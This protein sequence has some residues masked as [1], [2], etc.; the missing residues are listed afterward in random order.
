MTPAGRATTGGAMG[1]TLAL[2]ALCIPAWTLR[3]LLVAWTGLVRTRSTAW[4][5]ARANAVHRSSLSLTT[6][7]PFAIAVGMT[8]AVYATVGA[9]RALGSNYEI[10]RASCRER[11]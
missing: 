11:V 5:A 4:F 10:G 6:I 9:G 1:L 7:T 2:A 8:G 3:P